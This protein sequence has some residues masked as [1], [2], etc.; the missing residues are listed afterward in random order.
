MI[1]QVNYV[2][3]VFQSTHRANHFLWKLILFWTQL[4]QRYENVFETTSYRL[5]F[6]YKIIVFFF[7]FVLWICERCCNCALVQCTHI[8]ISWNIYNL[9][10]VWLILDNCVRNHQ[11]NCISL[12]YSCSIWFFQFLY[13]YDD[14][15]WYVDVV[16]PHFSNIKGK[17]FIFVFG[18][19]F[20]LIWNHFNL[21]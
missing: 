11:F 9:S 3:Y 19:F 2:S 7:S 14:K 5:F 12:V 4:G 18:F 8:K 13:I 15:A 16:A 1:I 17:C 10:I 21:I 6:T 20:L